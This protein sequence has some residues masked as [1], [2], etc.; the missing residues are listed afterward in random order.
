MGQEDSQRSQCLVIDDRYVL[1]ELLGGGGMANVYLAYDKAAN[2]DVA[3]KILNERYANDEGVVERFRRE[4][5]TTARL[6]HPNIVSVHDWGLTPHGVYYIVMECLI[7]GTLKD[8][9]KRYGALKPRAAA[10]VALQVADALTE[11][12]KKG[13]I[14]RDIKPQNILV[15]KTGSVKVADFG[16]AKSASSPATAPGDVFGTASYMSPEQAL[17]NPVGAQS[18]LYSLGVV[19]F[20]MLGGELPYDAE[21]SIG[22]AMKHVN[23]SPRSPREINP[24]VPEVLGTLT[25]KL[26][27]KD[28]EDRPPSAA[29]LAAELERVVFSLPSVGS[30]LAL[31]GAVSSEPVR[32]LGQGVRR[33]RVRLARS[34]VAFQV[35]AGLLGGSV[36]A[37]MHDDLGLP[38]PGSSV[39][40][41]GASS[42]AP[43][44]NTPDDEVQPS[45]QTISEA[46]AEKQKAKGKQKEKGKQKGKGKQKAK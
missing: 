42:G 15:T 30:T 21:T 17:G 4:A 41:F 24:S 35:G 2:R 32:A 22:T 18:D 13:V 44:G 19:L 46:P 5:Q 1:V 39:N 27:A 36:F 37:S 16:I 23:Q 11:A 12:H 45:E 31:A 40:S 3:L 6:S 43:D 26:L 14:H 8:H 20:E 7:R 33:R 38:Q 9:I 29:A 28:P 10:G 34:L 25:V